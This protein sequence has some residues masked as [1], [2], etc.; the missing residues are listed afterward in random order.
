[1]DSPK[2]EAYAMLRKFLKG[3][4]NDVYY[5]T[6]ENVSGTDHPTCPKCGG[7]MTFHGGDLKYGDGYWDCNNCNYSFTELELNKYL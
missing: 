3:L 4:A 2:T 6:N 5:A 7:T 1:M